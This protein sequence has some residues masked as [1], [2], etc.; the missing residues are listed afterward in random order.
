MVC[1][2]GTAMVESMLE[3]YMKEITCSTQEQ[4][5]LT[6]MIYSLVYTLGS[7]VAGHVSLT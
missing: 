7:L 5:G 4:I 2:M 3:P 6:F 1:F